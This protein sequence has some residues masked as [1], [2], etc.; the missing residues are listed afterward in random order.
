[1]KPLNQNKCG[2]LGDWAIL[3]DDTSSKWVWILLQVLFVKEFLNVY[4]ANHL[5]KIKY[6]KTEAWNSILFCTYRNGVIRINLPAL[7]IFINKQKQF[8]G[9]LVSHCC[10][11]ILKWINTFD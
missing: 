8:T 3:K 11:E 4:L 6:I 7:Q 9:T 10:F 2:L 1:M 5:E